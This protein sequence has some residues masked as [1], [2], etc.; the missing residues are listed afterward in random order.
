[1]F[2]DINSTIAC[3]ITAVKI[4]IPVAHVEVSFRS[5]DRTMPE[6][7]NRI[8]TDQIFELLFTTSQEAG[9]NIN[10]EGISNEKVHFVG[11]T[12]IDSLISFQDQFEAFRI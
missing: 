8:L 7:I 2:G 11:N 4:N 6:E 3:A 12:M 1:L 10:N 5:F 9:I